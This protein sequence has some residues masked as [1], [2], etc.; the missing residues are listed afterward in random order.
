MTENR[1]N[2]L[3]AEHDVLVADGAMGTALFGLGLDSGGCPELLNVE[4]P[5]VIAHVHAGYVQAGA[6]IILT[7]TFG[8]N[9][10]RLALHGL[11]HRVAELN[12][13]A[14]RIARRVAD[15][16]GRP[17][18]VAASIGPTGDLFEPLGPLSHDQ[19][20]EVFA[21]QLAAVTEAGADVLWI[22]TLSSW[23]EL[24]AAVEAARGFDLPAVAT[25][26]FDT[27]GRTMMGLAPSALGQWWAGLERRPVAVGANCGI[28]P[29]DAVA[30]VFDITE[31]APEAITVAKANCGMPLYETDRLV[32]PVLPEGMADY[33]ELAVRSG[34]R[35]VGACCGSTT[36]HIAAIRRAVDDRVFAGGDRP[37]RAEIEARLEAHGRDLVGGQERRGSRR[38]G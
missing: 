7:N 30:A 13:A 23:E 1:F 31:A 38:R 5:E 6:D 24:N 25:L 16:A 35:I 11:S 28:G 4:R 26:S 32:Y 3:L 15:R 14:V 9:R 8:G 12:A 17:V 36:E 19:G 22:E 37:D 10:R 27:N 18:A 2:R 21:E 33:V 20:V 29:G 34:A